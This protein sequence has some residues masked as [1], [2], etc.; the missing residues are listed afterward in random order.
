MVVRQ[1]AEFIAFFWAIGI[2]GYIIRI[3]ML[4]V[5]KPVDG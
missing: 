5:K 4:V 1:V 3:I 2:I